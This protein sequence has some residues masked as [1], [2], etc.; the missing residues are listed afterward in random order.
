MSRRVLVL[1]RHAKAVAAAAT[2]EQRPL[3]DRG[4]RDAAAAGR[5]LAEIG[6]E[7]DLAV[8][9][10]ATRARETWTDIAEA[11]AG[12]EVQVDGRIYDNTVGVLLEVIGEVSDDIT[13]LVLVG[14]NPSM[15]GLAVTLS[16]G[17]GEPAVEAAIRSDYPTCGISVFDVAD[18][19]SDLVTATAR[20]RAFE[21]PRG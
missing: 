5:W 21:A 13:T 10:S 4:H 16:D 2:D 14:H 3:A 9:S 11:L 17:D 19:W 7:P 6:I 1:V 15:H 8:V 12:H 18:T 20:L